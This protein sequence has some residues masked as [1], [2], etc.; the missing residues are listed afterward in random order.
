MIHQQ[1]ALFRHRKSRLPVLV[2]GIK[3][4]DTNA[5]KNGIRRLAMRMYGPTLEI[6]LRQTLL[7]Q[8]R[9]VR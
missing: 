7:K 5:P 9:A 8:R 2:K 1:A 3:K 6:R 4:R